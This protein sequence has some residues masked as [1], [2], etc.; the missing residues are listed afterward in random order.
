MTA[1]QPTPRNSPIFIHI[2]AARHHRQPLLCPHRRQAK[3]DA[4]T[5]DATVMLSLPT[6]HHHG[7]SATSPAGFANLSCALTTS[8]PEPLPGHSVLY[9]DLICA[10]NHR[11]S[12]SATMPR[13]RPPSVLNP[14]CSRMEETM[15]KIEHGLNMDTHKRGS[16]VSCDG[17]ADGTPC[18]MYGLLIGR[19][20][21]G[22]GA[23][24]AGQILGNGELNTA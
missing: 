19:G 4:S 17:W 2:A 5:T 15:M 13:S 12:S 23:V 3:L 1:I 11:A 24:M 21:G 6:S 9:R 14:V 7:V 10:K 22:G 18:G 8:R 20:L 16:A